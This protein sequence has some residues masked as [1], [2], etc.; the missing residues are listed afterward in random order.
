VS[1]PSHIHSFF[2]VWCDD[3]SFSVRR[4]LPLWSSFMFLQQPKSVALTYQAIKY[5]YIYCCKET[6][7]PWHLVFKK[8]KKK[9]ENVIGAGSQFR[10]LVR[11]LQGRKH[12]GMACMVACHAGRNDSG[13]ELRLL[14]SESTGNRK[15]EIATLG[16]AWAPKTS[17]S[18]PSDHFF[19]Q[20]LTYS[21]SYF[22]IVLLPMGL[23]GRGI[24]IQTTTINQQTSWKG[25][26]VANV[27]YNP[28]QQGWAEGAP[29][30]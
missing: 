21:R 17:R 2:P 30:K 3:S 19:Q 23:W 5:I 16:T 4:H 15:R 29:R 8:K 24:F 7:W 22:L 25:D 18:A 13:E 20:G 11:Y 26:A 6:P 27:S 10:H 1:F 12:G 14:L 28:F 9:T